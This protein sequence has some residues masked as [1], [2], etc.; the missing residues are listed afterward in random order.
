MSDPTRTSI[1]PWVVGLGVTALALGVF[2]LVADHP[3]EI[4]AEIDARLSEGKKPRA[5][6]DFALGLWWAA[7]TNFVLCLLLLGGARHWARRLPIPDRAT[8]PAVRPGRAILLGLLATMALGGAMRWN[9]A[10]RSLWW[11]ELWGI[12]YGVV[13]YYIGDAKTP[14]AERRFGEGSWQRAL[15]H[16]TRPMN[17][18]AASLPAR[19]SHV[20][21][22]KLAKPAAPHEFSD[23]AVRLPNWLAAIAA[24][25]TVG[26][27]G[28]LWG[29]PQAGLLAALL[30]AVHPWHIRYGI[31]LRGYSWLILWTAMGLVWL[32]HLFRENRTRWW[33]WWAFGINQALLVW[34][35]PHG[36]V[37]AAAFFAVAGL[38]IHR[39]W[40]EKTDRTTAW[41]RLILVNSVAAMLYI[42]IFGPN[43]FQMVLWWKENTATHSDHPLD[44]AL[45]AET[46]TRLLTGSPWSIPNEPDY[47]QLSAMPFS[48]WLCVFI[49][50]AF[51]AGLF[52]RHDRPVAWLLAAPVVGGAVLLAAF[53]CTDSYY[54]SRFLSFLLIPFCL[55]VGMALDW[56]PPG[57]RF[58]VLAALT[59]AI[60]F[61][62]LAAPQWSVLLSRP[63]SPMRDVA[64]V[65]NAESGS[66]II[67]CYGHGSEMLPIYAPTVRAASTLA[68]LK[69]LAAEAE[70]K[71]L[72]LLVTYGYP[73]LNRHGIPDGFQWLDD[74]R[75]FQPIGTWQ[76]I[77][78]DFEF[79]VLR[80]SGAR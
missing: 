46:I 28:V 13:G 72:S 76:G 73:A 12:K 10:H 61:V 64:T 7:L 6:S 24:I 34:S 55:A 52:R 32:T 69:T 5:E 36:A 66:S 62:T 74:P 30:L 71:G 21:W 63:Y 16:Y 54:Y 60:S 59:V 37:V 43:L 80:W 75:R 68:D 45:L 48:I 58:R 27:L 79:Q 8:F 25:G 15:W 53:G 65:L 35:F 40:G 77:D 20:A 49:A 78:P 29:R 38:L 50:I 2:L 3:G 33:P 17:H 14:L 39:A 4:A 41:L 26:L 70:S 67:A 23:F 57:S 9:L 51:L 31:D 44:A 22:S 1:R 19:L 47:P 56:R 11:D 42:Q 18:P